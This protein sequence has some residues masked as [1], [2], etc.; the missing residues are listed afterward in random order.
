MKCKNH[1]FRILKYDYQ[2][3]VSETQ[4][5]QL[6]GTAFS[7]IYKVLHSRCL[8]KLIFYDFFLF[9]LSLSPSPSSEKVLPA[10]KKCIN[11]FS[12]MEFIITC[13]IAEKIFFWCYFYIWLHENLSFR[14]FFF[15][16]NL[17]KKEF[18]IEILYDHERTSQLIIKLRPLIF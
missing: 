9:F 3:T 16:T 13:M 5:S 4:N 18:S 11:C 17:T 2:S 1:A 6:I 7:Q 8:V 10:A 12:F 15:S 14:I